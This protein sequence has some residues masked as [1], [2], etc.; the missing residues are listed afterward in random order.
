MQ[1]VIEFTGAAR[2]IIHRKE[3]TLNLDDQSTYKQ[4]I[5]YLGNQFP[6]LIGLVIAQDGQTL[7]SSNM[8]VI[9]GDLTTPA[10]IISEHPKDGDRL[11]LMSLISGG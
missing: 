5:R 10:M 11:I 3:I 7:L 1:I 2:E 6:Q 8:L 4:V 9:N